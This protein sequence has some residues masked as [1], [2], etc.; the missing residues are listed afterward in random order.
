MTH[1]ELV[2]VAGRWLRN[3]RHCGVVLLERGASGGC[4]IPDAIGWVDGHAIIVEVKTSR[5]DFR[6]DKDKCHARAGRSMGGERWYL[7]PA[8]V[9]FVTEIPDGHGFA[10]WTGRIV[11]RRIDP[12]CAPPTV[13]RIFEER[14]LLLSELRIYHA[15]GITYQPV[16]QQTKTRR[17]VRE[18]MGLSENLIVMD[19]RSAQ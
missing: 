14:R 8:G 10:E 15:Q 9:L 1:R 4:E 12:V 5:E 18:K 13:D 16:P 17:I 2:D 3:T 6:R 19:T 7:A 11:R